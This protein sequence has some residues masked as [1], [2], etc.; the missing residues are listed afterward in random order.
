MQR[1]EKLTMF[2]LGVLT[3]LV[4][5]FALG[6]AGN[7]VGRYRLGTTEEGVYVIDTSTGVTKQVVDP[8]R[9]LQLGIPFEKMVTRTPKLPT[10]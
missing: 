9:E 5:V 10:E 4:M 8:I 6:A 2:L 7:D 3:A 1:S